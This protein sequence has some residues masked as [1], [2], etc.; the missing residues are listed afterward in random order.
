MSEFEECGGNDAWES[1]NDDMFWIHITICIALVCT[2]GIM[3]GLQQGLMQITQAQVDSIV[4]RSKRER[5]KASAWKYYTWSIL[6]YLN[7]RR[8]LTLVT[9]LVSNAIAMEALPIFLDKLVPSYVA[10]IMSVSLVVLFGEVIPQ[11]VCLRFPLEFSQLFS[12]LV[13]LLLIVLSPIIVPI[14]KSLDYL[15][16]AHHHK[17]LTRAGLW[18]L[19]E[20][21]H[22]GEDKG[23]SEGSSNQSEEDHVDSIFSIPKKLG[24]KAKNLI[25]GGD[26]ISI[27]IKSD[28]NKSRK[29]D[30]KTS[31][32]RLSGSKNALIVTASS[33]SADDDDDDDAY[34]A[35]NDRGDYKERN[36][37]NHEHGEDDANILT[38]EDQ[39]IIKGALD[40]HEKR[41]EDVC[42][43]SEKMF[44]LDEEDI[45]DDDTLNT[46]FQES[47]SRIPITR[48]RDR[49][50]I[51]GM[52]LV[53]QINRVD[54]ERRMRISDLQLLPIIAVSKNF[55]LFD[56]LK[57]FRQGLS[58]MAI[59]LDQAHNETE[60]TGLLKPAY[61]KHSLK[62]F[63]IGGT[64]EAKS[65]SFRA[66]DLEERIEYYAST[67]QVPGYKS[68]GILTLEDVLETFLGNIQ[69]ELDRTKIAKQEF[70]VQ[71]KNVSALRDQLITTLVEK[72]PAIAPSLPRPI[73]TN[74]GS[75]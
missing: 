14:A 24:K 9:L 29:G 46:I 32:L 26:N 21:S 71:L 40:L 12:P 19:I 43:P 72:S 66:L 57:L 65:M 13:M 4:P 10:I 1:P 27:N 42:V 2:G 48:N 18:E 59:V 25:S 17:A 55:P 64:G 58:H 7:K 15:L 11:A 28:D 36:E 49:S 54:P 53:R 52:L 38:I 44:V 41:V 23:D 37:N 75:L 8:H 39:K 68:I 56:M 63:L 62:K 47:H 20:S 16:G 50:Q 22:P 34:N 5:E 69:D 33:S 73:L 35:N 61:E 3:S 60:T 51:I 30:P 45:L 6:S 67:S 70:D 31:G 74:Y